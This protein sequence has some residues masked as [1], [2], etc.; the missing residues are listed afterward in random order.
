MTKDAHNLEKI[1]KAIFNNNVSNEYIF[2]YT[3]P[4]V[5]ST[6]LVT[7]LRISLGQSV[8]IAHIH[9][10]YMLEVLSGIKNV[11]ICDIINYLANKGNTVYVIDVY[12]T[13]IERK[14][15]VF[16]ENLSVIHF[17]VPESALT[18]YSLERLTN[19]F[20]KL[21][22]HLDTSE[23]YFTKYG[24]P[25]NDII[26]FD[27]NKKY[28]IQKH[29]NVNY[30]KLR[31]SDTAKWGAILSSIL[32]KEIVIVKDYATENKELG[33]K[34]T[35]FKNAYKL[36]VNYID[37]IKDCKYFNHY[38]NEEERK[39]YLNN[40]LQKTDPNPMQPYTD[41]EYAFYLN[42]SLENQSMSGIQNNEEHYIDNNCFCKLCSRQRRSIF[43]KAKRGEKITEKIIHSVNVENETKKINTLNK[44]IK[45]RPNAPITKL[46]VGMGKMGGGGK[47]FRIHAK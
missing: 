29:N 30:I 14:M 46:N 25:E 13:P 1:V 33:D 15:S 12:R 39:K 9:D 24:I 27:A 36:P 10:E 3:P 11:L 41:A 5:G 34:Y 19:R 7:S 28:S 47:D 37:Y 43:M 21:F 44:L 8:N 31:L 4:K 20:N 42:V 38:N 16:F 40:W 32:N 18:H 17:N 6:T 22:P 2:V 35:A 26:P 23:H 45:Q